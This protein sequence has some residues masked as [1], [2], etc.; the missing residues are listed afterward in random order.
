MKLT[1]LFKRHY[2]AARFLSKIVYSQCK[3]SYPQLS[4]FMFQIWCTPVKVL[5]L[6]WQTWQQESTNEN[7]TYFLKMCWIN[8]VQCTCFCFQIIGLLVDWSW[9]L[10]SGKFGGLWLFVCVLQQRPHIIFDC[11]YKARES[12]LTLIFRVFSSTFFRQCCQVNCRN[13][14]LDENFG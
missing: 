5:H 3:D 13:S 14:E 6:L 10:W 4:F 11:N 1:R 12:R 7:S 2:L 8:V 9:Q